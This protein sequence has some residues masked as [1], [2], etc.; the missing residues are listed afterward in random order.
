M[1]FSCFS[2]LAVRCSPPVSQLCLDKQT[3]E[4]NLQFL[5]IQYS[6]HYFPWSDLRRAAGFR[7]SERV[8]RFAC[9]VR[10]RWRHESVSVCC[11]SHR[12]LGQKLLVSSGRGSFPFHFLICSPLPKPSCMV[13]I[14]PHP[15]FLGDMGDHSKSKCWMFIW[16]TSL[17]SLKFEY[18]LCKI[19][20]WL[21]RFA[22]NND[23]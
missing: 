17:S 13:D 11:S 6:K 1:H 5:G 8:C 15:S 16:S 20:F 14:L 7:G 2:C 12:L 23:I 22:N 18:R 19:S 21:H 9:D 3:C 10:P 4:F